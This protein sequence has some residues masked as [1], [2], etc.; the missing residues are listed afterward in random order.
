M[1]NKC[2]IQNTE[3]ALSISSKKKVTLSFLK[4]ILLVGIR[5]YYTDD[6][7]ELKPTRKGISLTVEQFDKLVTFIP[8]IQA[9]I[10][11]IQGSDAAESSVSDAIPKSSHSKKKS[12]KR[13]VSKDPIDKDSSHK[14]HS[15]SKRRIRGAD[16]E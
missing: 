4:D 2:E 1:E 14:K 13:R 15:S 9:Q 10:K 12:S 11:K 6:S 3:L 16:T 8:H 7:D 5:E